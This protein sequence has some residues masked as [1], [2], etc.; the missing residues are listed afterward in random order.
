MKNLLEYCP[1]QSVLHK[2]NPIAKIALAFLFSVSAFAADSIPYLL[3][4]LAADFLLGVIGGITGKTVRVFIGLAK[5]SVFLF[6]L[7]LLFSRGGSRVFLFIT[8]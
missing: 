6:V 3:F 1:G 4:L 8:D 5:F 2:M 7:Q